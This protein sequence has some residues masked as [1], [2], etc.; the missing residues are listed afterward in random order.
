MTIITGISGGGVTLAGT[1]KANSTVTVSDTSNGTTRLVGTVTTGTNG[2]WSLTSHVVVDVSKIH[3]YTTSSTDVA[4]N[5]GAMP[6][7]FYLASTGN[8]TLTGTANVSDVFAVMSF[9][10]TDVIN[11]FEASSVVG[12]SH[13]YIDFSGRGITSFSQVQSMMSGST[14]TVINIGS[15]KTVTVSNVAPF[16]FYGS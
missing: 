7:N 2:A 6:G 1:S 12:A 13:D 5:V 15:G 11:G 9:K 14:S 10:G 16:N 4:G 3:T 8:D